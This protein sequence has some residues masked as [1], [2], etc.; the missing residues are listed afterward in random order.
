MNEILVRVSALHIFIP[1]AAIIT[2]LYIC[3]TVN[4][5]LNSSHG[6]LAVQGVQFI[7]S[8][9]AANKLQGWWGG[10]TENNEIKKM[11]L[12]TIQI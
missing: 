7:R 1:S 9:H 3:I 10:G 12:I 4:V 5:V 2:C 11:H 8:N 6:T